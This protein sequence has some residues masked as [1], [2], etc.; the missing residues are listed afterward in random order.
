[1]ARKTK[2]QTAAND[3]ARTL[4]TQEAARNMADAG[5]IDVDCQPADESTPR[6]DD[7]LGRIEEEAQAAPDDFAPCAA[8]GF[9][10]HYTDEECRACHTTDPRAIEANEPAWLPS[11]AELDAPTREQARDTIGQ[12]IEGIKERTPSAPPAAPRAVSGPSF[13]ELIPNLDELPQ[14]EG[15]YLYVF[16]ALETSCPP[17]RAPIN[18][19]VGACYAWSADHAARLYQRE[20]RKLTGSPRPP[21]DIVVA[22]AYGE[23][24]YIISPRRGREWP[25]LLNVK[26]ARIELTERPATPPTR[27]RKPAT[28]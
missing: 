19:I 28:A 10:V 12:V 16:H 3:T 9:P 1:M 17:D 22:S 24:L 23:T 11:R 14:D 2:T 13:A 7:I 15:M 21:C 6:N 18:G 20:T 4:A 25:S 26:L 5:L 8:C 27:V